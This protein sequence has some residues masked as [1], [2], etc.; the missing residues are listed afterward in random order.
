LERGLY[1]AACSDAHRVA[2]VAEVA[3]GL[4]RIERLYGPEEV[5]FLFREEPLA[6]LSGRIP[7]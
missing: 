5:D 4:A 2:D 1:H 3:A 7:E 6:L